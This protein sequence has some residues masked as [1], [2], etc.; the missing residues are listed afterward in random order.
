VRF[1][2]RLGWVPA[3]FLARA[4]V[5]YRVS[6]AERVP[7][8]GAVI[9]ASNHVSGWDPIL[10]GLAIRRELHFLAKEEL[11]RNPLLRRIITAYN[12]LPVRRGGLD[13]RALRAS[14]AVLERGG[15]VL[16]FPEGTRSASGD[17]REPKAGVGFLASKAGAVIVPA[18][19]AGSG[20]LRSA[21]LRRRPVEVTFGNP[22]TSDRTDSSETYRATA[23]RTMEEVRRLKEEVELR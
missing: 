11:F 23:E 4:F 18:Y 9:I 20:A 3:L 14:L 2:Y 21:F 22:L 7:A 19:I 1:H 12:A 10:V 6:G 5:G 17:L 15:A 13:R 8:Q 16:L